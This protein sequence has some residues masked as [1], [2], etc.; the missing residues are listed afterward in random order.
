MY[1]ICVGGEGFR[2]VWVLACT[3]M[4]LECEIHSK[5]YGSLWLDCFQVQRLGFFVVYEV[6]CHHDPVMCWG[7]F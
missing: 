5:K 1:I 7:L 6:T 3:P 4:R 2:K